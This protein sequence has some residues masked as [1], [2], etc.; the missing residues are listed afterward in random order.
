MRL[1]ISL[2]HSFFQITDRL[3]EQMFD[4]EMVCSFKGFNIFNNMS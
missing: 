1:D 3:V 2:K 4:I